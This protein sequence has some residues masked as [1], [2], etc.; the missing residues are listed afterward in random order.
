MYTRHN[1]YTPFGLLYSKRI[2][3]SLVVF[4]SFS[5]RIVSL[6]IFL[7]YSE[8]VWLY[9]AKKQPAKPFEKYDFEQKGVYLLWRVYFI[10]CVLIYNVSIQFPFP[11]YLKKWPYLNCS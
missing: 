7:R 8:N 3:L 5:V 2:H 9:P 11:R 10:S 6:W 4:Y 1:K